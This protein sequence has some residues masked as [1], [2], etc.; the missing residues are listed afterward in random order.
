MEQVCPFLNDFLMPPTQALAA[1][2][3]FAREWPPAE[4][5]WLDPNPAVAWTRLVLR[6]EH[7]T[8]GGLFLAAS[9]AVAIALLLMRGRNRPS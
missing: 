4:L 7:V 1:G 3:E 5:A 6:T 8:R 9:L 2:E